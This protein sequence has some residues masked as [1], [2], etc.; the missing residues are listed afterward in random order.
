VEVLNLSIAFPKLFE[1]LNTIYDDMIVR[2]YDKPQQFADRHA[3]YVIKTH[4]VHCNCHKSHIPALIS[5]QAYGSLTNNVYKLTKKNP[6]ES[7]PK[8][9]EF[10]I[11]NEIEFND[12]LKSIQK[13]YTLIMKD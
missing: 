12:L 7:L 4:I 5:L 10:D 3:Y 1:I 11:N 6:K 9:F 8:S 13:Q 2:E